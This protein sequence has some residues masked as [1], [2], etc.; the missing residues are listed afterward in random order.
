[1]SAP[2]GDSVTPPCASTYRPACLGRDDGGWRLRSP[3]PS[4]RPCTAATFPPFSNRRSTTS[5]VRAL[6]S[7]LPRG[8]PGQLFL[9]VILTYAVAV[10]QFSHM[11]AGSVEVAYAVFSGKASI[12]EYLLR[13]ALP[14]FLGNTLGGVSLVAVLNHA[15]VREEL[16]SHS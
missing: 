5:C 14:T 6:P 3:C 10:G 12:S 7:R 15:P 9:I 13:F 11:I 2:T 4:A 1:M 8:W 16:P